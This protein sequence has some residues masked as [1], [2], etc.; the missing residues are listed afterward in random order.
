MANKLNVDLR[1]KT[2]VMEGDCAEEDR[3]IKVYEGTEGGFG[4]LPML[5]G[6]ALFGIHTKTNKPIRVDGMEVERIIE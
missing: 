1:G 5:R 3:T 2:V 4:A 6:T